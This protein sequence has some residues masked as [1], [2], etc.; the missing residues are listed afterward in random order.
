M[1]SLLHHLNSCS[2]AGKSE[3]PPPTRHVHMLFPR[4]CP[5]PPPQS[6]GWYSSHDSTLKTYGKS[7]GKKSHQ[8]LTALPV[9]ALTEDQ[10]YSRNTNTH[11]YQASA[12]H[13]RSGGEARTKPRHLLPAGHGE[14]G[15]PQPFWGPMPESPEDLETNNMLLEPLCW[16]APADPGQNAYLSHNLS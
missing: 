11:T 3:G 15:G 14:P 7:Q 13:G 9:C 12:G 5:S 10:N 6:L 8:M 4:H 16:G 2:L 1:G